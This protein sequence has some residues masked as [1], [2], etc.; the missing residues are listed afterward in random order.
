[1]SNHVEIEINLSRPLQIASVRMD[2][3]KNKKDIGLL[4]VKR[5]E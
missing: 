3:L 1:M 5:G 2:V 4:L